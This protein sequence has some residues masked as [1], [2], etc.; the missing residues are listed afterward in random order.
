MSKTG[1]FVIGYIVGGL[2]GMFA[3]HNC[4]SDI[5][6]AIDVYQNKTTLKYT[7]VD[8]EKIDSTVIWKKE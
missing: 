2:I 1:I 5:P 8:G 6:T 7:I 3:L 4:I